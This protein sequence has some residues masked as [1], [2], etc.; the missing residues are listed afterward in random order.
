[1]GK[2]CVNVVANES[3]FYSLAIRPIRIYIYLQDSLCGWPCF[4][5]EAE[6]Q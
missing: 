2:C 6:P 5:S 4:K 3:L 1:M